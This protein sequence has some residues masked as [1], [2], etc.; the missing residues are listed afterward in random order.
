AYVGALIRTRGAGSG[1]RA[2]LLVTACAV[3]A[4][5]PVH[6]WPAPLEYAACFFG[7]SIWAVVCMV[8]LW[9]YSDAHRARRATFAYLY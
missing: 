2:L 6:P 8:G 5:F 1:L 4:S 9:Q 3:S 7:G